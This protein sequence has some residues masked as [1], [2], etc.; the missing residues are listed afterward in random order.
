M[1]DYCFTTAPAQT[2]VCS[3]EVPGDS[4]PPPAQ[5]WVNVA[6]DGSVANFRFRGTRPTNGR[7]LAGIN[8]EIRKATFTPAQKNG[9]AV[10]S[11][12]RVT[13]RAR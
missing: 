12:M 9:R 2:A 5:L 10:E 4:K 3:V 1:N 8:R 11:W 6:A 7:F 13:C